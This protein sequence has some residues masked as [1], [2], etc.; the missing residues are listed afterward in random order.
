MFFARNFLE[1]IQRPSSATPTC[2]PVI[3][4]Q[5][6]VKGADPLREI[7]GDLLFLCNL[8]L[9]DSL[10]FVGSRIAHML[11]AS[12]SPAWRKSISKSQLTIFDS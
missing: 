4:D 6:F 8:T 10:Q 9:G 7:R 5:P 12:F 3:I 11:C 2:H 1:L